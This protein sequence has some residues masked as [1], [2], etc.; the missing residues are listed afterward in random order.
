MQLTVTV[1]DFKFN[2]D[3]LGVRKEPD[4]WSD[5]AYDVCVVLRCV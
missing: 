3:V 5:E 2:E 4:L 1:T